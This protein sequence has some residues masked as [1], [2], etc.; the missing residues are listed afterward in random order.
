[1]NRPE[2]TVTLERHVGVRFDADLQQ[3]I[4]EDKHQSRIRVQT[5]EREAAG[6]KPFCFGYIADHKGAPINPIMDKPKA[7]A[8]EIERQVREQRS[9]AG[10]LSTLVE[11]PKVSSDIDEDTDEDLFDDE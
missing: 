3:E 1:M 5:P 7:I 10:R 6:K 2:L 9:D 4:T 11:A 8:E